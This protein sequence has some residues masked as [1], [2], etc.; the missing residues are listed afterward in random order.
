MRAYD[1]PAGF[2]GGESCFGSDQDVSLDTVN[3]IAVGVWAGN[4]ED[5]IHAITPP[6]ITGSA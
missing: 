5:F 1:D 2:P 6:A 3:G 4:I